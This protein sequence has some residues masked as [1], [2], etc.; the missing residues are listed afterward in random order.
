MA[1]SLYNKT[2]KHAVHISPNLDMCVG[3]VKNKAILEGFEQGVQA[4][5]EYLA[6]N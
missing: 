3:D 6:K 5:K 1:L 4:T 2:I